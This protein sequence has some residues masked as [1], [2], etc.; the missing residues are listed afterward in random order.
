MSPK[1]HPAGPSVKP[2]LVPANETQRLAALHAL[3]LLD[4]P[5]E[6]RFDVIVDIAA[7]EFGVPIALVSLIDEERQWVKAAHGIELCEVPRSESFCSRVL[8]EEDSLVIPD[9]LADPRFVGSPFVVGAPF[10]RFYAGVPLLM[11]DGQAIGVMCLIDTRPR[12]IRP[13]DRA[14]LRTL[15]AIATAELLD[16]AAVAGPLPRAGVRPGR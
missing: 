14:L 16:A 5:R 15:A 9:T 4:T 10:V 11:P 3:R 6:E 8:L 7:A 13:G 12:E 2:I 1:P